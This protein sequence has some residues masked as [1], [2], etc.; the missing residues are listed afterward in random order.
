MMSV[1]V[2][3]VSPKDACALLEK[4]P[5]KHLVTLKVLN[6]YSEYM[7]LH[8][9]RNADQW[10]LLSLLPAE[11][12]EWDRKAYPGADLVVLIDGNNETFKA[13]H[14]A[15]LPKGCLIFKTGDQRLK[16]ALSTLPG[17]MLTMAFTSFTT[18]EGWLPP[19]GRLSVGISKTSDPDAFTMFQR[20]GYEPEELNR[21]FAHGACWFSRFSESTLA[22]ACF[23]FQ[24]YMSV[25]EIAGVHTNVEFRN[26]GYGKSVV[27]AALGYLHNAGLIPRYQAKS[28]NA[29]S[30]ALA[31]SC[32]MREFITVDH[33]VYHKE[34]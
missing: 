23:V 8:L 12:S 16:D 1:T 32:G 27:L 28:D 26:R 30:I 3:D 9:I 10:A 19:G 17:L 18:P 7:R 6:G 29:A 20:N 34:K 24:N 25:W 15:S 4:E 5:L 22:S 33:Y 11:R 21:C 14:L 13:I 2:Q 31:R